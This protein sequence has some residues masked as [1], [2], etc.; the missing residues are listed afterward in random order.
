MATATTFGDGEYGVADDSTITGLH[1]ASFGYEYSSEMAQARNHNGFTVGFSIYED[2]TDVTCDGVVKTAATFAGIGIADSLT[3]ANESANTR[4][5]ND[6]HVIGTASG[7]AAAIVT[8]MSM[9]GTNTD[10]QTGSITLVFF[11]YTAAS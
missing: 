10:F 3:L 1:V 11:P 9:A 7:T 2:K 5:L 8:G 6:E 4:S